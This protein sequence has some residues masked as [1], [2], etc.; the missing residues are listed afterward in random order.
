VT[1]KGWGLWMVNQVCD[2]VEIR[3]GDWGTDVR[4]HMRLSP[5]SGLKREKGGRPLGL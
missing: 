4:L 2:L 3:S 5:I 1:K